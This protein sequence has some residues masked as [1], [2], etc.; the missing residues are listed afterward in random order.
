LHGWDE[1]LVRYE[2][3]G[4][5]GGKKGIVLYPIP[6][7]A[8]VIR[9][10]LSSNWGAIMQKKFRRTNCPDGSLLRYPEQEAG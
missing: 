10:T 2:I 9:A 4:E 6:L 7:P 3:R 1:A 8:P 5:A